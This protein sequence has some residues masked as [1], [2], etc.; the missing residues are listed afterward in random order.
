MDESVAAVREDAA[1]RP[2]RRGTSNSEQAGDA[3]QPLSPLAEQPDAVSSAKGSTI[4]ASELFRRAWRLLLVS[5]L[6]SHITWSSQIWRD[7]NDG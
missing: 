5:T 4:P 3:S 7:F 2:L 6:S 1:K